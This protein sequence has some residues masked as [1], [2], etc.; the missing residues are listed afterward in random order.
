MDD[1]GYP[2]SEPG[3]FLKIRPF[4]TWNDFFKILMYNMKN[5]E[6]NTYQAFLNMVSWLSSHIH[7]NMKTVSDTGLALLAAW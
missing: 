5:S 7:I 1:T 6:F 4:F 2:H 3:E